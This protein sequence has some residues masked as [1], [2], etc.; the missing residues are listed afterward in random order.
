MKLRKWVV[1]SVILS[2]FLVASCAKKSPA[3]VFVDY[4]KLCEHLI[5]LVPE[6]SR[7]S[8]GQSCEANYKRDLASCSNAM[9]VADCFLQLRS[10]DDRQ[11]CAAICAQDVGKK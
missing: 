2:L 6:A 11:S 10:W 4:G 8:F 5:P 9:A 7:E 1:L 3:P